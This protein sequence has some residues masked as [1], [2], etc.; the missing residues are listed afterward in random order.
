MHGKLVMPHRKMGVPG[1]NTHKN[2]VLG[3]EQQGAGMQLYIA[4]S[5][6]IDSAGVKYKMWYV[7]D[8]ADINRRY[9]ICRIR[10]KSPLF[11][12]DRQA[13]QFLIQQIQLLLRLF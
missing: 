12:S 9:W 7:G 5:P 1:R 10:Y 11:V 6:V 3:R 4:F 2:P 8:S 13:N